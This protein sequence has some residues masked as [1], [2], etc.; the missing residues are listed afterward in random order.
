MYCVLVS[1]KE[2]CVICEDEFRI[3]EIIPKLPPEFKYEVMDK[4]HF[5]L[6]VRNEDLGKNLIFGFESFWR[7]I[8][9]VVR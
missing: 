7:M 1:G 6:N 3:N 5:K 4:E 9:E 2:V 8:G